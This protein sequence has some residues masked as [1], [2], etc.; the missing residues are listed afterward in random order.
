[1]I[2]DLEL[3]ED[4]LMFANNTTI[5]VSGASSKYGQGYHGKYGGDQL[6]R[7][8]TINKKFYFF[9]L[10]LALKII[11]CTDTDFTVDSIYQN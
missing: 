8:T 1:M 11:L 7:P 10:G 4:V 5:D 6:S 3:Q 9:Q 2:N